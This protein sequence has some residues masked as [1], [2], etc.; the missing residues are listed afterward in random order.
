M[1]DIG[2]LY[3]LANSAM[4]GI[5]KIGKTTRS[6]TERA[7]E[8][9]KVTG[10]PTPFIVVYEQLFENCSSAE[11]FVHTFLTDKGFRISEN[12]EFF[13][14]PVNEVVRAIVHAPG[15]IESVDMRL[16]KVSEIPEQKSS[17]PWRDVLERAEKYLYGMDDEL[18]NYSIALDLYKKAARLGSVEAITKLGHIYL[19][20]TGVQ[21]DSQKAL[22]YY[23]ESIDKGSIEGYL[24]MGFVYWSPMKPDLRHIQNTEK[25]FSLFYNALFERGQNN[26]FQS[27][28][29]FNS[30]R[31]RICLECVKI[32]YGM[33]FVDAEPFPNSL[34]QHLKLMSPFVVNYLDYAI[35]G[36]F[37]DESADSVLILRYQRIQAYFSNINTKT[38]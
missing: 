19:D 28:F 22:D 6:S 8:L 38:N 1:N 29:E 12:R 25:C 4:P 31:G 20:G 10:L 7:T 24:H 13:S 32:V 27:I 37:G 18:Q 15:A 9:S 14:A 33:M 17:E 23:L 3:V 34:E 2:Y 36:L 16:G 5:V 35:K 11:M 30:S 26:D 21:E